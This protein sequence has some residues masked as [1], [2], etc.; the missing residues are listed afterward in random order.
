MFD[1]GH[2]LPVRRQAALV[3]ISRGSAYYTAR[4]VSD[5][6]LKRMRRIDGLHLELPFAGARMLRDLLGEEG[7]AAGRKRMTS[8]RPVT[9]P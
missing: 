8:K 7:I 3:N 5:D 1:R 2:D 9:P 4:P 6:D